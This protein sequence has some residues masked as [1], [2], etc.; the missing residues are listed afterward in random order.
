MTKLIKV[1]PIDHVFSISWIQHIRCNYDCMYC[2]DTRHNKDDP[3]PDLGTMQDHWGQIYSKIKHKQLPLELSFSGGE[4]T[5]NKDFIPFI[6]WLQEHHSNEIKTVSI[7]TNGSASLA[8]YLKLFDHLTS[9]SFST[10]YE[11]MSSDFFN[12]ID[13]LNLF[14]KAN[15][16]MLFVNVMQEYWATDQI[17]STVQFCK[18]QDIPYGISK[19]VYG[20]PG[21]RSWPI[22]K[23]GS[24]S[25]ERDDLVVSGQLIELS[26][27]E[28]N[29]LVDLNDKYYNACLQFD[30]NSTQLTFA[31][32][33][34][35]TNMHKFQDWQCH[36]GYDRIFILPD[37][38]VYS[39][40]C[41]NDYMGKLSDHSFQLFDRPT[42]CKRKR[43]TNN[44]ND[45]QTTKYAI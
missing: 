45:L 6:K 22:I 26:D 20:L 1:T 44:P 34:R 17:K 38:S 35:F 24:S 29:P 21:S 32:K 4:T 23:S 36:A 37:T 8:Y 9:I 30:D 43:C 11:Y 41:Q 10:H 33:L 18:D 5:I 25:V 12:K 31:S 7:T 19:V 40:E 42:I 27:T 2:S 13:A 15:N 14:A 39:G 3:M 16:K 28:I